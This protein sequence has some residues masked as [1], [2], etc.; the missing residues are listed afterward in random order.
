MLRTPTPIGLRKNFRRARA[1]LGAAGQPMLW[2]DR[3]LSDRRSGVGAR[4][5]QSWPGAETAAARGRNQLQRGGVTAPGG[6]QQRCGGGARLPRQGRAARGRSRNRVRRHCWRGRRARGRNRHPRRC[7]RGAGGRA[8]RVR[9]RRRRGAVTAP[10]GAGAESALARG[11]DRHRWRCQRGAGPRGRNR[12]RRRFWS[13]KLRRCRF[14]SGREP[15]FPPE[16][17]RKPVALRCVG[18]EMEAE[19]ATSGVSWRET[20]LDAAANAESMRSVNPGRG[21]DS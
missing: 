17:A 13:G 5:R 21:S 6:A 8:A 19:N 18:R 10:G 1:L 2:S 4:R 12:H 14:P 15:F 16:C 7:Q 11:R 9:N 20:P 3:R